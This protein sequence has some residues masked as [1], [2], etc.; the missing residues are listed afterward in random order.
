[1]TNEKGEKACVKTLS[2]RWTGK[3]CHWQWSWK[4]GGNNRL[5]WNSWK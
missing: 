5:L 4:S 1:M 3:A 2:W